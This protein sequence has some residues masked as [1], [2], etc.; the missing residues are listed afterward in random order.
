MNTID[1]ETSGFVTP[2]DTAT[3]ARFEDVHEISCKGYNSLARARRYGRWWVLKGLK[4]E[5]RERQLYKMMLQKEFD[6]LVSLQHP[7]IVAATSLE[8]VDGRGLCIVMEWIDGENLDNWLAGKTEKERLSV[9]HQLLDAV[10]YVHARQLV[11]RDLKPSNVMVMRNGQ[12]VKLIDFGLADADSFAIFKQPAGTEGYISPEQARDRITDQRNDIYSIGCI[13]EALLPEKRYRK[14]VARCKAPLEKR[15][16][17]V[18]SLGSDLV[19][20]QRK[21][22]T[23]LIAIALALA[24]FIPLFFWQKSAMDDFSRSRKQDMLTPT[25]TVKTDAAAA[26]VKAGPAQ[27]LSLDEYIDRG[28]SAIDAKWQSAN[29][30]NADSVELRSERFVQFVD[31]CNAYITKDYP[32]SLPKSLTETDRSAIVT[33]LSSYLADRYVTP[34]LERLQSSQT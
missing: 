10:R 4:P 30:L 23:I 27:S 32:V 26:P 21:R 8:E 6:L 18:G 28:K 24:I 5:Y 31:D 7:G 16:A 3:S 12:N 9:A 14:V 29:D 13:L 33:A 1:S 22:T 2:T 19:R 11:H 17:G 15:Y 34:T 20:A 25:D